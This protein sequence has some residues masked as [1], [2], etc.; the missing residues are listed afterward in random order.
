MDETYMKVKGWLHASFLHLESNCA[1]KLCN[2]CLWVGGRVNEWREE[3][4]KEKEK[5]GRNIPPCKLSCLNLR[6][7]GGTNLSLILTTLDLE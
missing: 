3:R 7:S 4:R 6:T 2:K 5:E 1:Q